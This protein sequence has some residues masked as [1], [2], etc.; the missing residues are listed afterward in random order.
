MNPKILIGGVAGVAVVAVAVFFAVRG[1]GGGVGSDAEAKQRADQLMAL[2]RESGNDASY[3]SAGVAGKTIVIKDLTFKPK[4]GKIDAVTVAEMRIN[5]MD[6]SN[7]KAPAFTDVEYKGVRFVGADKD[8]G[9]KRMLEGTG[10]TELV[11][12]AKWAYTYDKDKKILDLKSTDIEAEGM[13]TLSVAAKIEGLDIAQ[14]EELQKGGAPDMGKIM[15][16]IAAMRL[17]GLRLAFKDAGGVDRALAAEAKKQ[18]KAAAELKDT[19]LKQLAAMKG[20]VPFKIAQEAFTA[21]ETFLKKPGTIELVAA[22]KQPFPFAGFMAL[23]GRPDP[24]ALD[25]LK[26]ELGLTIS[27]K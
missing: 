12:N 11:V 25:K 10:L 2:S 16:S 23:A 17:H 4:D 22:P 14:I 9:F 5:A 19:A 18:G 6:W 15:G 7:L 20:A 24:A 13:G 8:P 3:K 1:G 27:A 21:A 26:E